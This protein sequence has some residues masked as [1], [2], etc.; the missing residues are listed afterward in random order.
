MN[1]RDLEL[2]LAESSKAINR[3]SAKLDTLRSQASALISLGAVVVGLFVGLPNSH[4]FSWLTWV[5]LGAFA[6]LVVTGLFVLVP[7]S[8]WNFNQSAKLLLDHA[9]KQP[10]NR[11]WSL[12]RH[13]A[14]DLERSYDK[15]DARIDKLMLAYSLELV[16]L[17]LV[18]LFMTIDAAAA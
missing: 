16:S 12:A 14:L 10:S 4:D 2:V 11:R 7:R 17:L 1:Q 6:A 5:G 15:N 18:V 3:Q 13:L 8:G 9:K